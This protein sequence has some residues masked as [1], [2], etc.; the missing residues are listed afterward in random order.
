MGVCSVHRGVS[1]RGVE[2]VY[3]GEAECENVTPAV[4]TVA[5]G[6]RSSGHGEHLINACSYRCVAFH[7]HPS[8]STST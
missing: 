1:L 3:R 7:H 5:E 4:L 6:R 2:G 8:V